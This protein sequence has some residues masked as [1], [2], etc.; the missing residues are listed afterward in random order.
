MSVMLLGEAREEC[1]GEDG[2][3][4]RVKGAINEKAGTVGE[5]CPTE[6]HGDI[7]SSNID[8]T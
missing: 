8:S 5:G 6:L 2:W 1:I 3:L 7:I 4:S